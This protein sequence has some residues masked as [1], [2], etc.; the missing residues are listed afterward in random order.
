[1]SLWL[2][3][4]VATLLLQITS[5]FL[6][7]L[8]PALAPLLTLEAG[9]SPNA[10]GHLSAIGTVGS[11]IFLVMGAPLIRRTGPIRALQFGALC[12]GAGALLMLWPT[13]A[14]LVASSLLIGV[15][16]GPSPPA[17]AEILQKHAPPHRRSLIFSIKQA[18]VP[19]GGILAGLALPPLA[20][21]DWRLAI[22]ASAALALAMILIVQPL[23]RNIDRDRRPDQRLSARVFFAWSNISAPI[24][25][26]T[27][28]PELP[29]LTAASISFSITQGVLFAFFVTYLV[30]ELRYSLALAGA[31]FAIMQAGGVVGRVLLGWIADRIGSATSTLSVLALTSAATTAVTALTTPDWPVWSIAL[32]SAA[33]GVFIASWNGVFLAEIARLAPREHIGEASAGS[34][35]LT[36]VGY[37][38]GPAAFALMAD[39]TGYRASYAVVVVIA[40][41]ALIFLLPLARKHRQ[42]QIT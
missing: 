8:A 28:A 13:A 4:L 40:L 36:F 25:A 31:M 38:V 10:I 14:S 9:L 5:A 15:G 42:G 20:A 37:V 39:A 34:T 27:L 16:Y 22:G 21:I 33:S 7:R 17:G 23:R 41:I 2:A 35:L 19:V 1:M 29:P 11:I 32:L 12:A 26:L 24:R 6:S 3:P 30:V 18:G